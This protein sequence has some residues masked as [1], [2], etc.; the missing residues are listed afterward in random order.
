[1]ETELPMPDFDLDPD[2]WDRI[3]VD[4]GQ[5]CGAVVDAL[6][7][8]RRKRRKGRKPKARQVGHEA[9]SKAGGEAGGNITRPCLSVVR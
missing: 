5:E 1:V 6:R 4:Q 3:L 9:D 7:Y 2:D 8:E